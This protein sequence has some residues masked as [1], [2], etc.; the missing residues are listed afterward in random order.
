MTKSLIFSVVLLLSY[1][2]I[3]FAQ[4]NDKKIIKSF[5]NELY[6][7]KITSSVCLGKYF[8]QSN[9]SAKHEKIVNN[10]GGLRSKIIKTIDKEKL[11]TI[12]VNHTDLK[13][14]DRNFNAKLFTIKLNADDSLSFWISQN[15]ISAILWFKMSDYATTI[16][17]SEDANQ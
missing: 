14:E 10:L 13:I 9:D 2:K 8:T 12:E 11:S 1:S 17:Y 5:L 16:Y 15:K 7:K 3:S 6:E 4:E